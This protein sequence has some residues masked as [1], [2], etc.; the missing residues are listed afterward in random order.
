MA[1]NIHM[2]HAFI[3]HLLKMVYSCINIFQLNLFACV[4]RPSNNNIEEKYNAVLKISLMQSFKHR[5]RDKMNLNKHEVENEVES[6]TINA[7]MTLIKGV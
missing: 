6:M 4:L 1:I 7:M 5:F 2:T 3:N